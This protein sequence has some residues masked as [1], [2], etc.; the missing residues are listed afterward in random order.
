[1]NDT[2]AQLVE[3]GDLDELIRQ[4]DRLCGGRRWQELIDLRDLCRAALERGK[5]LWP[6]ASHAEYRLA[7]EGPGSWSSRVVVPGA[8]NGALGPL[9][10]VA[11]S[12][13]TWD[14]LAA[15]LEPGPLYTVTAHERVVRGE[16]L[17]DTE[18][19]DAR[20]F[21]LPAALQPWE[22]AYAV[23]EYQAHEAQFPPPALP[24]R[25]PVDPMPVAEQV[26]DPDAVDALV[27]LA[28]PWIAESN[29]RAEAVA[30][31]GDA[32]A[33]IGALGPPRFRVAPLDAATAM[34]VMAWTGA[35]GGAHGRRR[36]AA[37]GRFGAWWALA[38]LG[39]LVDDWPVPADELGELAVS[40]RW[41]TWDAWEPDTGWRFHL[42]I[43]DPDEGLAWAVAATDAA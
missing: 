29:G 38:A 14:E 30:V 33:A 27:E 1:V 2:T 25:H 9:P 28:R 23:A 13:H 41:F 3:L 6:A 40:L 17:G 15:H 42:A 16:A 5:Q 20:V 4:I 19:L 36:G 32:L 11:A 8:G 18:G 21:D 37:S 22:P 7:L 24:E 10:E 31:R 34:A 35:S 43:D 12:T 26:D 39:A